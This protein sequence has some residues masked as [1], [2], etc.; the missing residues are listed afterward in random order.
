[1]V[2]RFYAGKAGNVN[3]SMKPYRVTKEAFDSCDTEGAQSIT[4]IYTSDVITVKPDFLQPGH[5]Y[6]IGRIIIYV[7]H[8]LLN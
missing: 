8:I 5:N 2:C 6:F 7:I 4:D 1:M 3:F